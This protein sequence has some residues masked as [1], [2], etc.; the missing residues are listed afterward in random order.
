M[1]HFWQ[2][3]EK[4][5]LNAAKARALASQH[6]LI[7]EGSWKWALRNLRNGKT[8]EQLGQAP[9]AIMDAVRKKGKKVEVGKLWER[10]QRQSQASRRH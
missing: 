1:Q 4:C 5:A 3:F 2:G 8:K 10:A 6:G 7:P 9:K